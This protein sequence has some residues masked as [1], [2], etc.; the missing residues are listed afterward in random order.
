[1]EKTTKRVE[2]TTRGVEKTIKKKK[3]PVAR[4]PPYTGKA[5]FRCK[6]RNHYADLCGRKEI[7]YPPVVGLEFPAPSAT[8]TH[9]IN[10]RGT[11]RTENGQPADKKVLYCGRSLVMGG[12]NLRKSPFANEFHMSNEAYEQY[13][14]HT[15]EL[16][17][18]M[19]RLAGLCLGC[20][21]APAP[22]HTD[23]LV[24]LANKA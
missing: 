21:C 6:S 18:M 17:R 3:P 15:P 23:V 10:M 22:C 24:K 20:W 5:C 8:K 2:K 13:I 12:W 14:I 16:M 11:Q 4:P 9:N 1:M 7:D 19:P